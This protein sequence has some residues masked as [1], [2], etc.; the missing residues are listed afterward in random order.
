M[1][2]YIAN[3]TFD[4]VVSAESKHGAENLAKTYL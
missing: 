4:I 3:V 1:S 2:L